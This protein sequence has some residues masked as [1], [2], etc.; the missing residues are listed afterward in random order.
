MWK[1][2]CHSVNYIWLPRVWCNDKRVLSQSHW[3]Q[4]IRQQICSH[5]RVTTFPDSHKSLSR[6]PPVPLG[7]N[8]C[9]SAVRALSMW[10]HYIPHCPSWLSDWLRLWESPTRPRP[11]HSY[12]NCRLQI[13]GTNTAQIRFSLQRPLQHRDPTMA[14]TITAAMTNPQEHLI[15]THKV[16]WTFTMT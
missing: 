11:I 3:S 9:P 6:P 5:H 1:S 15:L 10:Q 8:H 7:S 16:N 2:F 12:V 13:G 14:P 4:T